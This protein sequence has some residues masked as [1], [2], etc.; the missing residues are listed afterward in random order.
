MYGVHAINRL[1]YAYGI[2]DK[3]KNYA[4]EEVLSKNGHLPSKVQLILMC[5]EVE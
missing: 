1:R 5:A 3:Q 2:Q 4:Y